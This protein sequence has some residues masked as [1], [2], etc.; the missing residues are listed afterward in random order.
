MRGDQGHHEL[1]AYVLLLKLPEDVTDDIDR[2]RRI[3]L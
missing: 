2:A 3:S 1:L